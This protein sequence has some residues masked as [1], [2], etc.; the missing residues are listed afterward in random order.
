MPHIVSIVYKPAN[1]EQKP[2]NHYARVTLERAQLLAGHG[3]A[4][5]RKGGTNGRHVN[6]MLAE[7]VDELSQN[8][9]QTAPGEL[10]EQIVLAGLEP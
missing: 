9:F 10:G 1:V 7:V 6:I 3:I 5:D 4:G 2:A 8:G